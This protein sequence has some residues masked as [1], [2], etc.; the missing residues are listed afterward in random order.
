M[1]NFK[2][3]ALASA[4]ACLAITSA[5][6]ADLLPPPPPPV[7]IPVVAFSGWYLRGDIGMTNQQTTSLTNV[8]APGT[9]V[10]TQFLAFDSAPLFSNEPIQANVQ[11]LHGLASCSEWT[12]VLLSTL[13]DEAG[14]DPNYAIAALESLRPGSK[15]GEVL[16]IAGATIL[17][18]SYNSNPE[19][20]G[21]MIQTLAMRP[22][23]RRI[24]VA[25]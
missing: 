10:G 6:A 18:D 1:S 17:N 23:T 11:A 7:P 21:S 5:N 15:R 8:V 24:L 20:L 22:A 14:V 19:A 12:G 9:S 16:E 4:A 13:L 25:G 3:F 2:K